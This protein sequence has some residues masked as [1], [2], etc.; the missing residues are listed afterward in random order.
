[1]GKYDKN[2]A[3]LFDDGYDRNERKTVFKTLGNT[4]IPT[5]WNTCK[6]V[7]E[8]QQIS[9]TFKTYTGIG[10][11]TNKEVFTDVCAF[12]KNIIERYDE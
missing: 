10:H 8:K 4:K 3:V 11:E 12:F 6:S 9:A 2:D 7:Y 1:M 5:W